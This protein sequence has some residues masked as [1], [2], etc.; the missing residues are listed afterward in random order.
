MQ[1][2]TRDFGDITVEEE[3]V[4]TFVQPIFGFEG[5]TRFVLLQVPSWGEK[6]AWLQSL[7]EPTLCFVLMDPTPLASFYRPEIS[8]ATEELLGE[9]EYVAWVICTLGATGKSSTVNLKSPIVINTETREV[10]QVILEQP[11]PLRYTLGRE[12]C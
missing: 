11:Y 6:L 9:G 5:Y 10:V 8:P 1:Y 3:E 4:L 2:Q 12:E 7:E